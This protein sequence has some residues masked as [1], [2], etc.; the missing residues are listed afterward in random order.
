MLFGLLFQI[1]NCLVRVLRGFFAK[2]LR[3]FISKLLVI[4]SGQI[5]TF[6]LVTPAVTI[7]TIHFP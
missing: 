7:T 3:M 6:H 1:K 4:Y 5:I 2:L